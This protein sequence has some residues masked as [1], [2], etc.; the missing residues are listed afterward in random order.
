MRVVITGGSG[1]IGRELVKGLTEDGHEVVILSRSPGN[2]INLPSGAEAVYWDGETTEGWGH[3]VDGA[4]AVINLAGESVGGS[5]L[6]DVR[7]TPARKRR[8]LQ[9]RLNAGRAVTLAIKAAE[10]KPAV[11]IQASGVGYYGTHSDDREI[12]EDSP[13]GNDFLA[14]V[15]IDWEA[16][17]RAVEK[18]GVRRVVLRTGVVMSTRGGALPRQ[19]LP[20]RFFAGGPLGSGE[21]WFPWIHI[22]DEVAAIRFLMDNEEAEGV[23]N[24]SAPH[25]VTNAQFSR[26]LG[27]AMRRPSMIPA[28]AF[29]FNLMFGEAAT[30]LLDGQ[31]AVPS[32]LQELGFK[33]KFPVVEPAL[34]D[35]LA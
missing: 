2:V 10:Q 14:G 29:A 3:L 31:K 12:T 16:S 34:E 21:Q 30:I 5:G 8:I 4:G 33:F 26:A 35:L 7:W 23:F 27:S 11:L 25:P 18:M 9:S 24:L 6:L 19:M 20:F 32:R 17:T 22:A 1:L 13:A 28:P 15:V